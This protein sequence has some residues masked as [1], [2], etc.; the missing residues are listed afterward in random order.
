MKRGLRRWFWMLGGAIIIV[1]I[2]YNLSRSPEWRH[3][4]WDRL[5]ASMMGARPGFLL[6]AL[7][8][9]YATYLVRAYRWRIFLNP[10]KPSSLWVLLVGQV[11]GFSSIYLVGRAGEFVRP[12]YV[13]KK[14][15]LPVSALVAVWL[16]ERI[17]D[18]I[19]LVLLFA[20]AL[21]FQPMGPSTERGRSAIAAIHHGGDVMFVLTGFLV[22]FLVFFRF[23]SEQ[24]TVAILRALRFL[25]ASALRHVRHFLH[26]FA[27]SLEVIHGWKVFLGSV[28]STAIL[29]WLNGTIFWLVFKSLRG[30]LADLSWLAAALTMFCAAMGL[31]IQ[32]PGI[33]G[34]YQVGII[35]ALTEIFNVGAEPAAGAGILTW[36][37]ISVP[38]LALGL[39]L[40]VHEGLSIKK[41]EAIAEEERAMVEKE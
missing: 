33:G 40:L 6:L 3:F 20:A 19:F 29:W 31:V 34:G 30:E 11:L 5:W 38:C 1:L 23:R 16:M 4:S 9:V 39:A 17:F 14:E 8:T 41:L 18:T 35:L 26:S 2:F 28:A 37:M 36:I 22:L 7:V 15:N 32:F 27:S 25:P 13:A 24:V 21:Y 12:A 10:I